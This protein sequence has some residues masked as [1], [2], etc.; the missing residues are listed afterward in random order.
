MS[1]DYTMQGACTAE[2]SL[3]PRARVF[4]TAAHTAVGQVR[5]YTLEPY[6]H[7]CEAVAQRVAEHGGTPQ[8]VAAAWL[9]DVVEDTQV[10]LP[11]IE[12]EFG[13]EVADLVWALTGSDDRS[14]N[15]ET[16][17]ARD[18][19]K[20]AEAPAEAQTIKLAD[21]IDNTSSIVEHDPKFARVYLREKQ[22]LLAV[23][24]KGSATL[25]AVA[26]AQMDR[27][28]TLLVEPSL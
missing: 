2:A 21:L 10:T 9:H 15:R 17:K 13:E 12:E 3:V 16:R 18:C 24:T 11:D 25:R 1:H 22:A 8:M 19:A 26:T 5:K 4:A 7:H 6:H 27:A 28:W 14:V 23:L 20:L